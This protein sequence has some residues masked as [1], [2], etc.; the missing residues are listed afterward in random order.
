MNQFINTL[1]VDAVYTISD[2]KDKVVPILKNNGVKK[3]VLFGSYAKREADTKSD[4]DILVDSGLSGLALIG[5]CNDI[6]VTLRK[7]IDLFDVYEIDKG[8]SI[9]AEIQ[10]TGVVIYEE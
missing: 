1:D 5:L 2:I 6:Q 9:D 8:S 3:A 7:E 10:K 4:V